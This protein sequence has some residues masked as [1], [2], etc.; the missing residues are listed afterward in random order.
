MREGAA[1]R[2][3]RREEVL[4]MT[5]GRAL[6]ALVAELVMGYAGRVRWWGSGPVI[7]GAFPVAVRPYSTDASAAWEV[8]GRLAEL[9]FDFD[10]SYH[11]N[12]APGG[13]WRLY[14]QPGGCWAD[15]ERGDL[16]V[17]RGA[18][19]AVGRASGREPGLLVY[20]G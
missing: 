16:A 10:L 2:T 9:G 6:D 15:G 7:D 1:V 17:C 12:F 11:H 3:L 5:P 8:L 13:R 14:W 4:A 19:L 18:L 20:G